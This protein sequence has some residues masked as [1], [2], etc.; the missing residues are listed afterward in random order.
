MAK[1]KA[2][3]VL[4]YS[5]VVTV[6]IEMPEEMSDEEMKAAMGDFPISV[7]VEENEE[8]VCHPDIETSSLCLMEVRQRRI[9]HITLE[10]NS[11]VVGL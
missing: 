1:K 5:M 4:T 3:A 11:V 10:D 2:Q 7:T 8:E 9:T 6:D